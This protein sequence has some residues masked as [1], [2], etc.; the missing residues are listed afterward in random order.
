M[1][2]ILGVGNSPMPLPRFAVAPFAAALLFAPAQPAS[3][4]LEIAIDKHTQTMTVA[5]DGAVLHRWP[6]STGLRRYDTPGGRYTPFRM[7]VDHFSREWDDAPMPHS[8]FFTRKGH[9]IH[10]TTH[11]RNIGRPASHGCV[12]L[13]PA[14]AK[15]LFEMVKREGMPNVRVTLHG[16]TPP[17]NA[18]WLARRAAPDA[19]QPAFGPQGF[20]RQDPERRAFGPTPLPRPDLSRNAPGY[21]GPRD[22]ERTAS[23]AFG[24]APWERPAPEF[25]ADARTGY[26]L[27]RPDGSRVFVD[28]ERAFRPPPPPPPPLFFGGAR[29]F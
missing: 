13:E 19:A 1:R 28:R 4:L 7:E 2:H 21:I 16:K 11:L 24:P 12:R 20:E 22:A 9:A 17:A 27:V 6:V 14:N 3:A 5:R 26:W 15:L 10:G 8:I 23:P 18:P 25:E 29:A